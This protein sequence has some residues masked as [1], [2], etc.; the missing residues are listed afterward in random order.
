ME[1]YILEG[2]L[3]R[4]ARALEE[5]TAADNEEGTRIK[6]GAACLDRRPV[7]MKEPVMLTTAQ[8]SIASATLSTLHPPSPLR[9]PFKRRLRRRWKLL[10][11]A[12]SL[13]QQM[14]SL[15]RP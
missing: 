14:Y 13:T 7:S 4:T 5:D 3:P 6:E 1:T 10:Q 8:V 11:Q 12:Y 2:V 15:P 9:M